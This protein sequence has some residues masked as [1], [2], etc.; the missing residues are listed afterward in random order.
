MSRAFLS[1]FLIEAGQ[2]EAARGEIEQGCALADAARQPYSQVLIHAGEGL[3]HLRRG[4]PE[5]AVPILDATLK[6]CQRVFTMEA[7]LAGWLGAAL[8]EAGRPAEALAVTEESFRRRA[9]H[10]GGMYTWFYLFKAIG[11]AHAALGNAADALAWLDKAIQV[12]RD[13]KE[14]LHYAQGLKSR[15]DIRLRLA[16][17]VEA[18]SGDLDEA[19]RIGEQLGLLP[20][21]AECDL[22][23]ARARERAGQHQEARRLASRAA[24]AFRALGLER[25]LAEAERLAT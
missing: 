3:Y 4:Y 18:A 7:M 2:F 13:S 12:T 23:L 9:H 17:S 5:L 10:A 11:E 22:S 8:V 1:W 24:E 6:M 20:L 19:R 14:S 15:G 25:H 16:L 21:V